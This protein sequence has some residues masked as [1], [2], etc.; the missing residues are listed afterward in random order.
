MTTSNQHNNEKNLAS[1]CSPSGQPNW[2]NIDPVPGLCSDDPKK[3]SWYSQKRVDTQAPDDWRRRASLYKMGLGQ[4][5]NCDPIMLGRISNDLDT[6]DRNVV[7]RYSGALRGANEAMMDLFSNIEVKDEEGRKH[8]VPIIW[9]SQEKAV[10][11]I[12][13]DNVRQD[14]SLVVDRIRLPILA[15]WSSGHF[16]DMSRYTY[17][18]VMTL[19]PWLDPLGEAGFTQQE[20]AEKD[21]IFG[22][23]RGMP[24]DISYTLYIW[25]LY[26]QD[27]DQ[28]LEQVILRFSPVAYIRVKGVWWEIIVSIDGLANNLDIEPGDNKV[29]VMKYQVSMTA[30]SYLPQPITR[31]KNEDEDLAAA[32]AAL[33]PEEKLRII[34][35][36]QRK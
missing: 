21:T 15:L 18:K 11:A 35:E 31:I 1:D 8:I 20:K 13:Q 19:M 36:L 32:V 9:A 23:T 34:Q 27:M 33:S 28:I 16:I 2:K 4:H 26:A 7:Y 29:R 10:A 22:V 12:M 17:H 5:G 3:D 25:S 24:V 14:N 6:P 30:K